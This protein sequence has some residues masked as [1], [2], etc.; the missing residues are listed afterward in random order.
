V[1]VLS[2]LLVLTIIGIPLA[3]F[4][5]ALYLAVFPLAYVAAAAG[6]GDWALHRWQAAHVAAPRWRIAAAAVV[7]LLLMP[8]GRVPWLGMLVP[9]VLLLAGLGALLLAWR[10]PRPAV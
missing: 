3:L 10:R 7:L 4:S 6:L 5:L 9:F 2:L 1:P 8:L